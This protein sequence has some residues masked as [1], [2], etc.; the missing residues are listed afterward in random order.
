MNE[1]K[2]PILQPQASTSSKNRG[3][4]GG[5]PIKIKERKHTDGVPPPDIIHN[6]NNQMVRK[7]LTLR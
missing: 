2:L 1:E 5:K 4:Q 6:P 3:A 7:Q